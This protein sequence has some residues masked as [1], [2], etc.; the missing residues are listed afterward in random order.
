MG[1]HIYLTSLSLSHTH[2]RAH[3]H[4]HTQKKKTHTLDY[5]YTSVGPFGP[6]QLVPNCFE[7]AMPA[8]AY[9]WISKS[10]LCFT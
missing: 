3:T 6:P 1:E 5:T 8:H 10:P 4:T 9:S 2:T 7:L